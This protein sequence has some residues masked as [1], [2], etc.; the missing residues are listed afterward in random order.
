[1]I[2]GYKDSGDSSFECNYCGAYF[3]IGEALSSSIRTNNKAPIYTGCC[4][5]GEIKIPSSNWTPPFLQQLLDPN[6]G[7]E[8]ILFRENIRVYNSMF[9]FTSMGAK[10][11]YDINT[12]S[13]PYVFKICGQVHH[14]MGSVLPIEGERPK[15]AQ[16]YVYDTNHEISNRMDAI[17]PSHMN[18]KIKPDIVEGLIQMFD[19]INDLVKKYRSVR[20]KFEDGSLPSFNTTILG[21]QPTDSRQYELPTSDEIAGLIVGD[22]GEF[23]SNRDVIIQ[24]NDGHLKRIFKLHPKYM[25]LQYPLLF[26]YGE[27]GFRLGLELQ[28]TARECGK[29]I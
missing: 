29:K 10:I 19:E 17:D 22:I 14:L 25:S 24:S 1:M 18:K 13:G 27:N 3:W 7:R 9:A 26:L 23:N 16:L 11:D 2:V 12:K 28:P 4:Q 6:N 8:S 21:R 20:D 5:K 15:Y